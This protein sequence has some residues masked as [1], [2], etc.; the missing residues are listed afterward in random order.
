MDDKRRFPDSFFSSPLSSKSHSASDGRASSA[1]SWCSPLVDGKNYL[2]VDLGTLYRL[3][4]LV[5]YGDSSRAKW[6]ATY[7]LDYTIDLINWKTVPEKVR[8]RYP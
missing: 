7:R 2:Q 4:Y 1:S 3:D 5:T 8:R 6:V